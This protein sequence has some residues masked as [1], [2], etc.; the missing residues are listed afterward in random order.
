VEVH[1]ES[2]VVRVQSE[3]SGR[4]IQARV[5]AAGDDLVIVV[6][7]GD[8]PHVGVVVL[9]QPV[10]SRTGPGKHSAS[11]TVVT[12]P[13]HKEE[14]IARS[15]AERVAS[16]LRRVVVVTAGVHEDDIDS[17]GIGEYLRLGDELAD[18]LVR[19]LG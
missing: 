1:V 3:T 15:V 6:G 18:E 14:S 17:D 13:P 9:A 8:R 5:V 2:Q 19:V 10:P 7:G 12:I 16:E 4:A 11:V